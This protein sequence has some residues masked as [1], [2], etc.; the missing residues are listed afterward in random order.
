MYDI[1]KSLI[2]PVV[3]VV[4]LLTAGTLA[5]LSKRKNGAALFLLS[6]LVIL[7]SLSIPPVAGTLCLYLEEDYIANGLVQPGRLDVI[8]VLGGGV[9]E[10]AESGDTLPSQVSASRLLRAV[11]VFNKSGAAHLLCAGR[12]VG[13]LSEAEV[14]ARAAEKIGVPKDRILMDSNSR[15]TME[16]AIEMNRLLPDKT[17]RIGLVTSA[18]HMK[19]SEREFRAYFSNVIAIPSDFLYSRPRG[20]MIV[21]FVPN[22]GSLF[23]SAAVLH[24]MAGSLWYRFKIR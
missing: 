11:Q 1:S 17:I 12:G 6:A 20:P 2:D 21:A 22:T 16:H 4:M 13:A 15:N 8:V 5:V 19:R 24:E 3:L 7:Y 18:Y 9:V 14:M 23:K 10:A